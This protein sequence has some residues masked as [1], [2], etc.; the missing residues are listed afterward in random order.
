MNQAHSSSNLDDILKELEDRFSA[1]SSS[2]P[3]APKPR[4]RRARIALQKLIGALAFV[5]VVAGVASAAFLS[6]NNADLRQ[7]ASG[8][9]SFSCNGN[10]CTTYTGDICVDST[11]S[12]KQHLVADGAS[13]KQSD[14]DTKTYYKIECAP[15]TEGYRFY[16]PNSTSG[17]CF[18]GQTHIGNFSAGSTVNLND[19]TTLGCGRYQFDFNA[20]GSNP[21]SGNCGA[22]YVDVTTNCTPGQ[23][24]PPTNPPGG[25]TPTPKPYCTVDV[26]NR[27]TQADGTVVG[28]EITDGVL[29]VVKGQPFTIRARVRNVKNGVVNF[30]R[31]RP[32][33]TPTST[34]IL[35]PTT[36]STD[37]EQP[38]EATF[39]PTAVGRNT[40]R[41]NV[42][43][44]GSED[45]ICSTDL[46]VRVKGQCNEA[47]TRNSDC[48]DTSEQDLICHPTAQGGRCRLTANT[49]SETCELSS[50]TPTPTSTAK[51]TPTPT[52]KPGVCISIAMT[53]ITDPNQPAKPGNVVRFTCGN[54]IGAARYRFRVRQPN[55]Q[56][57]SV[58]PSTATS[59]IS[60]NYT[61]PNQFGQYAAQCSVCTGAGDN[62]CSAWEMLPGVT[63]TPTSTPRV[64]PTLT[65]EDPLPSGGGIPNPLPTPVQM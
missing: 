28:Q 39:T 65:P 1:T 31:F 51:P 14:S 43:F 47:C 64:F 55:G 5:V 24:P 54:V 49:A 12:S 48:A 9:S 34:F 2:A 45:A 20:P 38:Y 53:N 56:I 23:T 63:P 58:N 22:R 4:K 36:V 46:V 10:V 57:V 15:T 13:C 3:S 25:P 17:P 40:V 29:R 35:N 44:N 52:P 19:Y 50:P 7:Q 41:V 26:V 11:D 6:Q 18:E 33:A 42:R 32:L 61:I 27:V 59:N 21:A 62:T 16:C 8:A 60:A 30:V 37:N